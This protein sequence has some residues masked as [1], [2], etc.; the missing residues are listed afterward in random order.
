LDALTARPD[1]VCA[2]VL[3]DPP[4]VTLPPG[5]ERQREPV[6]TQQGVQKFRDDCEAAV[7]SC[8]TEL[9]L[10]PEVELQPWGISKAQLDPSLTD[11]EQIAHQGPW[12]EDAAAISRP[13][14]VVTGSQQD[15]V[16][17]GPLSRQRLAA[18]GNPNIEVSVIPGAGHTVRRDRADAYHQIVDPW[19][20]K[21]RTT[22]G[23]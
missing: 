6:T 17:V 12:T 10:W 18:L 11:R 16:L 9:P 13:T 23:S 22:A 5:G 20:G 4:W 8:R 7:T 3:E 19:I 21:Q 14:L 1:L 2:A 15:S